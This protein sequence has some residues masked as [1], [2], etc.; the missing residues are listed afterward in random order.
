MI[1]RKAGLSRRDWREP[2]REG[3]RRYL[4]AGYL[5]G[6]YFRDQLVAAPLK[7]GPLALVGDQR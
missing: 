1:E 6:G 2:S 7:V 4:T 3:R 5:R